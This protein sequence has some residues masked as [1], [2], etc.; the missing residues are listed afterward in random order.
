MDTFMHQSASKKYYPFRVTINKFDLTS[1][2]SI[3]PT[4]ALRQHSGS[5]P[6]SM[7]KL[8]YLVLPFIFFIC[9]NNAVAQQQGNY[10][11]QNGAS[12]T[13]APIV[14]E[15]E[16]NTT[17]MIGYSSFGF[18]SSYVTMVWLD[19][20]MAVTQHKEFKLVL[21]LN[22]VF[23][24][25]KCADQILIGTLEYS[26]FG[27]PI[28]IIRT[29]QSGNILRYDLS[30]NNPEFQEKIKHLVGNDNGSFSAYTSKSGLV[31][32]MYRIDG[33]LADTI[34]HT[35]KIE[36]AIANNYF[37]PF[38][39]CDVDGNGLHLLT[40][41]INDFANQNNNAF[42]MKLDSSIIHWAKSYD[43]EGSSGEEAYS[44][45]KLSNGN[46]AFVGQSF[47]IGTNFIQGVVTVVDPAGE[48]VWSKK[49]STS[50]GGIYPTAVVQTTS[51][52]LL[53]FG[54]N[55]NYQGI[56]VKL[57][58]S[59]EVIWKKYLPSANYTGFTDAIRQE[60]DQI[61]A[62]AISGGFLLTQ[63]DEE[64][65]GCLWED[66]P[67]IEVTDVVPTVTDITFNYIP[68][69]VSFTPQQVKPRNLST[70]AITYCTSSDIEHEATTINSVHVYPNPVEDVCYLTSAS[71]EWQMY[72]LYDVYG[73]KL[74][75]GT[76]SHQTTLSLSDYAHGIYFV[77][78]NTGANEE[79]VRLVH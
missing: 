32:S 52:D 49:I 61:L 38:N 20:N 3:I 1:C 42:M 62:V 35:K 14:L 60:N 16:N 34:Y 76:F 24:A 46:F 47:N 43:Y 15:L 33:N 57:S 37:R 48:N 17:L 13:G 68:D 59:G 22:F 63:L 50:G 6:K 21:P 71:Q 55:T 9:L 72:A 27:T 45:I 28:S 12:A 67:T 64:G 2:P 7:K 4:F 65:D 79:V 25:V 74:S 44:I 77:R 36:P 10:L 8:L 75:E 11:I 78:F 56:L 29:D 5:L 26:S 31:E 30:F 70:S 73:K 18:D 19:E 23:H 53:I 40:G 39:T 66:D 69:V 41:T 58:A 51:G 54:N